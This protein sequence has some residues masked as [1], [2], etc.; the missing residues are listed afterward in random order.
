MLDQF[1]REKE[2]PLL[3]DVLRGRSAELAV[4]LTIRTCA[5]F[6]FQQRPAGFRPQGLQLLYG[7]LIIKR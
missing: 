7:R 1:G 2:V 3:N 4:P 6:V 5:R